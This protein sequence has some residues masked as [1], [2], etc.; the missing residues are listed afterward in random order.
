M[1]I[2]LKMQEA[3]SWKN[4]IGALSSIVE[5]ATFVAT[6]NGITSWA[7]HNSH[8][9]AI[10]IQWPKSA[11]IEYACNSD[12]PVVFAINLED[13]IK[14]FKRID[15]SDSLEMVLDENLTLFV[16]AKGEYEKE[17]ELHTLESS[18]TETRR[19]KVDLDAFMVL[20]AESLVK[21]LSDIE[22][23]SDTLTI[24]I[25]NAAEKIV[26]HGKGDRGKATST[27]TKSQL[28]ILDIKSVG[29]NEATYLIEKLKQI[30]TEVKS[31]NAVKISFGTSKP[32]N[33]VFKI[34]ESSGTVNFYLSP[35]VGDKQ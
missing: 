18:I 25:D 21:A 19:P 15:N 30:M 9:M 27:F 22:T 3:A 23:V 12:D 24:T 7:M 29:K 1:I 20:S 14:S 34:T 8:S 13:V 4:V 11:F 32:L 16:K 2:S 5:E 35:Y 10:D 6:K 33:A 17:F 28:D 31:N 26:F